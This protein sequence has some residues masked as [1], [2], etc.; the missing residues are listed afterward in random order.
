MRRL[1][2]VGLFFLLGASP[3]RET[4]KSD[5]DI[6]A[7]FQNVYFSL[8]DKQF[9]VFDSTPSL[10]SLR[11]GEMVIYS[12][13]TANKFIIRRSSRIY[14]VDLRLNTLYD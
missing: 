10:N 12:S 9:R 7:E 4:Y 8:Q 2:L 14:E 6:K 13:G 11:D 1:Y 5:T 3:I